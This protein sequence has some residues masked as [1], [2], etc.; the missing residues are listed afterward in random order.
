MIHYIKGQ[1]IMQFDG[2]VVIEAG[3]IGYEI[4]VPQGSAVYQMTEGQTAMLYIHMAVREDDVSLYGFMDK[5]DL[6]LFKLLISVSGIGAKGAMAILSVMSAHECR[7]AIAFEDATMLTRANGIGKKIAQRVVLELKD[8]VGMPEALGSAANDKL[9][10]PQVPAEGGA[11]NE[12]ISALVALGYSRS[13]AFTALA[14]V[15]E[16]G[17]TSEDYIKKALRNL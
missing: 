10:M 9:G 12:A 6:K 15:Q 16:D 17:L 8:K 2:G 11:R 5:E 13:E 4:Y 14:S 3:G 7:R 1:Y